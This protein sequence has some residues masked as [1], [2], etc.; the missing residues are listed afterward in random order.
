MELKRRS[1]ETVAQVPAVDTRSFA[2]SRTDRPIQS[3]TN[4]LTDPT[5][6]V[7]RIAGLSPTLPARAAQL[8]VWQTRGL[9]CT[10]PE[11]QTSP[12]LCLPIADD[13][14]EVGGAPHRLAR[15]RG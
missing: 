4:T 3:S 1:T 7:L 10:A 2:R 5:L 14:L 9:V 11:G 6:Y 15:D 13:M 8:W 12:F